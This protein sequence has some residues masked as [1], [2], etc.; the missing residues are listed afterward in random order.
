MVCVSEQ[1]I[2]QESPSQA[3][4]RS[5]PP[6][7]EDLED[8]IDTGIVELLNNRVEVLHS[9]DLKRKGDNADAGGPTKKPKF[10]NDICSAVNSQTKLQLMAPSP[11]APLVTL[12]HQCS[13]SPE[14]QRPGTPPFMALLLLLAK[15]TQRRC[16]HD[17]ESIIWC[18]AWYITQ[19][20]VDW[21]G[22][23]LK[24]VGTAKDLWGRKAHPDWLPE[25]H[26]PGSEDLWTPLL[27]I[28]LEWEYIQRLVR[29]RMEEY[30]DEANIRLISKWLPD[31]KRPFDEGRVLEK[32]SGKEISEERL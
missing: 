11:V 26:R 28:S 17:F 31:A 21:R 9:G 19:G 15:D 32:G 10:P 16:S 4:S 25:N 20:L 6:E 2:R 18:L 22:R 8:S 13:T 29:L 23:S 27:R 3:P 14:L 30:S 1:A 24:Q 12:G 7:F 5:V